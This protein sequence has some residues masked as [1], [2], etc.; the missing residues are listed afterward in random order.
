MPFRDKILICLVPYLLAAILWF[1][2]AGQAFS[3]W[4]DKDKQISEKSKE[5]VDLRTH[6][7]QLTKLQK[8]KIELQSDIDRLRSAV[9]K[10]ANL[11]ILLID[12]EKMCLSSGMDLVSIQKAEGKKEETPESQKA[13]PPKA[14][15]G[16]HGGKGAPEKPKAT[17]PEEEVGLSKVELNTQV[18]GNYPALIELM[19]KLEAYQRVIGINHIEI[20]VPQEE[21]K[22]SSGDPA[23]RLKISF[24]VTA[25]YLP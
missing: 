18:I 25:Y 22:K 6:L 3:D 23:D 11:D 9:P 1:S 15:G 19:K 2:L 17:T 10:S 4:E 21:T 20:Q 16:K 7:F 13:P 24:L 14:R 5:E 12:L 8:Q